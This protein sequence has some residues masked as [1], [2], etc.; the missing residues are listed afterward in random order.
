[1]G[2][3]VF[4]AFDERLQKRVEQAAR[5]GTPDQGVEN[6]PADS[7]EKVKDEVAYTDPATKPE[8]RHLAP[9]VK[10]KADKRDFA[11][12]RRGNLPLYYVRNKQSGNVWAVH[13]APDR[14]DNL[15]GQ[16]L[17]QV[18][19]VGP[20]S[21]KF[22][23]AVGMGVGPYDPNYERLEEG[24]AKKDWDQQYEEAPDFHESEEHFLTGAFLPVWNRI[25]GDRPKIYRLRTADGQ[26]IVGRHVPAKLVARTMANLGLPDAQARRPVR[27]PRADQRRAGPG[28][29]G[30]RL[31]VETGPGPGREA[32]RARRS[33]WLP[34]GR[35]GEGRGEARADQLRYAV[36]HP[37]RGGR[38]R[39]APPDHQ[40]Q[41]DRRRD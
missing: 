32:D 12:T 23:T 7:V 4:D 8:A 1:M 18:K 15:T 14:T 28:H 39:G 6:Y 41:A 19:M 33:D 37:G 35:P 30:E 36:L 5:E 2:G 3:K 17:P 13:S 11:R 25:P 16:V 21:V 34:H 9:K 31:A 26:T 29:A 24:E 27:R 38:G 40:G 10:R 20:A 22:D